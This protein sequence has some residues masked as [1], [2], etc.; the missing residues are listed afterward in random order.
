MGSHTLANAI[1][2]T[3]YGGVVTAC[4]LAQGPDL[5]SSVMPFILRGV[6]LVGI[7]SV[8]AP[9]AARERAWQR[10]CS[11]LSTEV[12]ASITG[13][14]IGLGDLPE[15]APKILAGQVRGRLLV[16]PSQ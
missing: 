15:I 8:M 2:Q 11:D 5:P 12:L 7:D 1:A 13:E 14:T 16:D 6:S 3:K 4:G 9:R 10:L